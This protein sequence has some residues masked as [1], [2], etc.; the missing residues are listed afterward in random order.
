MT[1][2]AEDLHD[3]APPPSP[4]LPLLPACFSPGQEDLTQVHAEIQ[5]LW[6][7][8][9]TKLEIVL[10][11]YRAVDDHRMQT[12]VTQNAKEMLAQQ[13]GRTLKVRV[14]DSYF[15]DPATFHK[16]ELVVQYKAAAAAPL[17][18]VIAQEGETLVISS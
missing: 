9:G 11:L 3:D 5:K 4:P 13:G 6:D 2:T 12:D 8:V 1:C 17:Q 14:S 16:K 10:A 7:Q 15:S 18:E